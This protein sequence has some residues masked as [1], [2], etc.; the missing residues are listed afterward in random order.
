VGHLFAVFL[1]SGEAQAIWEKYGGQTSA[2]IPGTKTYQYLQGKQVLYMNQGQSQM[3]DKLA[4]QYG[5]ILGFG[6]K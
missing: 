4:R 1:T 3:V 6:R 2:F 5:K